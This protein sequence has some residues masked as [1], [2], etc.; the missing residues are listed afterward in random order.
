MPSAVYVH[1][2]DCGRIFLKPGADAPQLGDLVMRGVLAVLPVS[3]RSEAN[4]SWRLSC[5]AH[6]HPRHLN[7]RRREREPAQP[8]ASE[9][10]N[11]PGLKRSFLHAEEKDA[12]GLME[13]L[14]ALGA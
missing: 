14:Q 8:Q 4:I 7:R 10:R 9:H 5:P 1:V 3:R 6:H 11:G 12:D 2:K 13:D